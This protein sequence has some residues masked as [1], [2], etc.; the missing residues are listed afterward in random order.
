[1]LNR[2]SKVTWNDFSKLLRYNRIFHVTT[3]LPFKTRTALK[4]TDASHTVL[5]V[6]YPHNLFNT[7]L[8]FCTTFERVKM[9]LLVHIV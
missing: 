3:M 5:L 8:L 6:L 4:F 2:F 1:M 9:S 7:M